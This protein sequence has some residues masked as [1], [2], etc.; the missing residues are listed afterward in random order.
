M[1][2][3]LLALL[4]KQVLIHFIRL[5]ID[6]GMS[7]IMRD[8]IFA[9]AVAVTCVLVVSLLGLYKNYTQFG[10]TAGLFS[11]I[12]N[13][14]ID[15]WNKI[16]NKDM[17]KKNERISQIRNLSEQI[18]N[19]HFSQ[20]SG[21]IE[22]IV[23]FTALTIYASIIDFRVVIGCYIITVVFIIASRRDMDNME[24]RSELKYIRLLGTTYE[25]LP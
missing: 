3:A 9:V 15:T 19:K 8:I 24:K 22:T 21:W 10:F 14:G 18:A 13:I 6:A 5:L 12:E 4:E 25:I 17:D 1:I 23:T 7:G 20:L 11:K 2:T 16:A